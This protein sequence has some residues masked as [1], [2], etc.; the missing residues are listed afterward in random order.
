MNE[1]AVSLYTDLINT[2]LPIA[3]FFG[4]CNLLVSV[5]LKGALGGRLWF[6]KD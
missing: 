2:C 5:F 1:L 6:G 3:F 4:M